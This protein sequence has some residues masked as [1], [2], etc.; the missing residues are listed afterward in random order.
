MPRT[1]KG[2]AL[3][4]GI[5][6]GGKN[7]LPMSALVELCEQS[8]CRDVRTYIQ[9]GNVVFQASPAAR[10]RLPTALAAAITERFGYQVP[11]VVRSAAELSEVAKRHPLHDRRADP[12]TLH[13]AFLAAKP[14]AVQAAA[15]DPNRSPPDRF[16]LQG[17]DLYLCCP[18]GMARTKLTNAY[19][20]RTL[21]TVSTVRNW[22]TVLTL[23]ELAAV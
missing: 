5:N 11:V 2:V 15:L 13:V 12:K 6:V 17:R 19:L 8:G 7:K 3:L 23:A 9:S 18:N 14:T 20:D 16:L 21:G 1:E 22:N 4:R 10:K